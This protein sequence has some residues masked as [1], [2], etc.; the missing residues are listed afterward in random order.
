MIFSP[1]TSTWFPP[2]QSLWS[3]PVL[4]D[5]KAVIGEDYPAE[6]REFFVVRLKISPAS[7][8]TLVEGLQSLGKNKSSIASIKQTIHAINAMNPKPADLECL[9]GCNILPTRGP[10][11]EDETS[12]T[13]SHDDFAINDREKLAKIFTGCVKF[14]DFPL[15][16]V[17]HLD[18]FLQAL[19]LS[20]NFLSR[21]CAEKTDCD[22]DG[23]F[24]ENLTAKFK[25]RA[26]HLLR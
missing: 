7:L 2:S 8:A 25:N 14:L 23:T 1:S 3:S 6:L 19:G 13:H 4:I 18:P 17:L 26:Y 15:E 24:D 16:E 10:S 5:G 20:K 22:D 11:L 9:E 12:L 21:L